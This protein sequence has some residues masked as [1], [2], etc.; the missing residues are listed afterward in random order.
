M[1]NEFKSR[2]VDTSISIEFELQ[3]DRDA[4][5]AK[6][7]EMLSEVDD[8]PIGHW[9]RIAKARG[10]T[11][12]SD[13]LVVN[14][15]VELYRKVDEVAQLLKNE[16]GTYIDLHSVGKLNKIG[17]RL[18]VFEAE[19]LETG[20]SYYGRINMPVFPRRTLP[21]FFT[22]ADGSRGII[23][24]IHERDEKDM[25]GYIVARERTLIREKREKQWE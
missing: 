24:R 10:E 18:I 14:L 8:D 2:E 7:F 17:H 3:G 6:E 22:A 4:E 1:E 13:M 21:V 23:D 11:K 25:D 15:V 20:K 5:F 12:D 16:K 9:L 19:V